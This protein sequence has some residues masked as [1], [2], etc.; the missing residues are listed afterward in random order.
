LRNP[1]ALFH[2]LA[3]S[4]RYPFRAQRI[5]RQTTNHPYLKEQQMSTLTI[6]DLSISEQLNG[7]AMAAV[8]GGFYSG[9]KMPSSHSYLSKSPVTSTTT[10]TTDQANSLYQENATGNGSAVF[11]GG[12]SAYNNQQG[13]NH[14]D[15]FGGFGAKRVA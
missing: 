13:E 15:S 11:G 5:A 2:E 6:K 1:A 9:F 10:I 14:I 3:Q 8:R 12:I 4:M 7:K